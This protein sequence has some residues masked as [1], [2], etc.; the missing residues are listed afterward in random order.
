MTFMNWLLLGGVLAFSIPLLI[1]LFNR[2]KFRV[3]DW[4]AMHLLQSVVRVNRKRIRIEQLI[5]LMIRMAIPVILALCMAR[6]VIT[7]WQSLAGDVPS[8]TVVMIDASYSM[9]AGGSGRTRFAAARD[10]A[11]DIISQ[12]KRGSE[13]S[14]VVM[15]SGAA[16]LTDKPSFDPQSVIKQLDTI[17]PTL[18]SVDTDLAIDTATGILAKATHAKRDLIILS[19][20]QQNSW[21]ELPAAA[22]RRLNELIA[23]ANVPPSVTFI[24]VTDAALLDNVSVD[25]LELSRPV[26]GVGQQ[27]R[28]RATVVNHASQPQE[29]LRVN[30]RVDG[31]QTELVQISLSPGER[32]QVLFTH[33]F[34]TTGSHLVRVNAVADALDADNARTL[35]V[36]VLDRIPVLLIDG[37]PSGEP[38]AGETDFLDIALRPYSAGETKL[39][40]L[41]ETRTVPAA[42]L[43]AGDLANASVIVLANV[44]RLD[45]KLL[46]PLRDFVRNGGALLVFPGNRIDLDW[47]NR[48]L[49]SDATTP[50]LPAPI[51][52]ITG[53]LKDTTQHTTVL[54]QHFDH[55]ALDLFN[56]QR[57]GDLTG[58]RIWMWYRY[59]VPA[60]SAD[61]Q[62]KVV[63]RLASGDPL[64]VEREVGD[65]LVIASATAADADWSNLPLRPTYLPLMQ[66]L[67][68]YAAS[69]NAEPRNVLVGRPI[70]ASLD[71]KWAGKAFKLTDA[72]GKD[73][74]V[75]AE[76]RDRRAVV[77]FKRTRRPGVYVLNG[78]D[79]AEDNPGA[80]TMHFVVR[81]D[82]N[83]SRIDALS[84]E[85]LAAAAD[86]LKASVVEDAEA[87]AALDGT[88]RHGREVW[89]PLLFAV[90]FLLFA[91][92][93]L[94][95]WFT[96]SRS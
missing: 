79:G 2:S 47:Y 84:E 45:D 83:E 43:K 73:H 72:A 81:A 27:L 11:T 82:R 57:N 85:Q 64:L 36:A 76:A 16:P 34:E 18:G 93:F 90:A 26:V 37:D 89:R 88:R 86:A 87:Y 9:G 59:D 12:Q 95:Q 17:T 55:P 42:K 62:L 25:T 75:T 3:V 96:R 56:D 39:A 29:N 80:P 30:L 22:T 58:G 31:E 52:K 53:D 77:E 7:G 71:P 69:R 5:L 66:Q 28:L 10:A 54:A 60:D 92:L 49:A 41:I 1:H 94:Q 91:E 19:D 74:A 63:A 8:S 14:V 24:P 67:V 15:G 50:L 48:T 35:A 21:S 40:D 23:D 32:R 33:K 70:V 44:P 61:D 38:L 46:L 20:F 6:P 4:G 78:P 51:L 13:I 65:G 68:T